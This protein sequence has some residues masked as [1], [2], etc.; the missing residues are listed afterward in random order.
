M[1]LK[2][3]KRIGEDVGHVVLGILPLD[4]LLWAREWTTVRLPWPF[5]G[6]WPPGDPF[7]DPDWLAYGDPREEPEWFTQL[8]RV[9][10][11][12]RDTLGY[13]IGRTIRTLGLIAWAVFY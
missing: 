9:E 3:L 12:G 1:T 4:L 5:K 7:L 13:D 8:H 6:Q 2:Q 11:I 10:D